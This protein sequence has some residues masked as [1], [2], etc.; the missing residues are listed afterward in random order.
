L[1][2]S[3]DLKQGRLSAFGE[4]MFATHKGLSRLY[5]VSC[6]ELDFL[7]SK[8]RN[9]QGVLGARMMG[10]GFGGCTLNIIHQNSV[11]DFLE[12]ARASYREEFGIEMSSYLVKTGNGTSVLEAH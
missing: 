11:D 9:F 2:G 6:P 4:K 12:V 10:G 3:A 5:Q 1:K 8:A 7:V